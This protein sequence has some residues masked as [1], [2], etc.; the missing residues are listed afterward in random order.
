[1]SGWSSRSQA[2]TTEAKA[3]LISTTSMSSSASLAF[4][5]TCRVAGI[6]A[7]S[8]IS[9]SLAATAKVWK[10]ARG[11]SPSVGGP[12]L[13][14]DEHG[15]RP[16]GDLRRGAG[17]DRARPRRRRA[18]GR[19]ASRGSVS[20]RTPSSDVEEPC[21]RRRRLGPAPGPRGAAISSAKRPSSVAAGG[22][23]VR[24]E[25]EGVHL[26]AADLPAPGDLL[27]AD[28]LVDRAGSA[29][30]TSGRR[31]RPGPGSVV[32]PIGT[33]VIDSTPPR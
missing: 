17:G 20:R 26:L 7:V 14:H 2:S 5:R 16:V 31:P 18:A 10:R 22:P 32:D 11:R 12:L 27:G 3:S 25:G 19:P 9:G 30:G 29:G 13:A 6:G 23:A 24:L 21:R 33:R 15:G 4:S 1:M 8:M 28:A